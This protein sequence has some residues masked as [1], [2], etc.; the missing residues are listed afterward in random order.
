MHGVKTRIIAA[1]LSDPKFIE[2]IRAQT[3]DIKIGLLVNNA[4]Q[5]N[6]GKFLD[7]SLETQLSILEV[8]TRAPLVLTHEFGQHMRQRGQGGIII[9]SSTVSSSGAPYNANYAATKA[10]DFILGEGLQH[11]LKADGVAVQVLQPG[12]TW[13]E[14]ARK[15]MA[16]A[17][18]YMKTIM[19]EPAPVVTQSLRNLGKRTFVIPGAMNRFMVWM[20]ST[21]VPRRIAVSM[22]GRMMKDMQG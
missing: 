4:G 11:E 3:T 2:A 20:M 10:Y 12:G 19:M 7:Q 13:T 1:D 18:N 5:Y 22:W 16:D 21:L 17:P 6:L 14:G 8:N 15:M 9:V